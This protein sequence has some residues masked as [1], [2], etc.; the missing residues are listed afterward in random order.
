MFIVL[1]FPP[2]PEKWTIKKLFNIVRENLRTWVNLENSYTE[3]V[4][5]N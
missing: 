4:S 5:A 1:N 3:Y 2:S